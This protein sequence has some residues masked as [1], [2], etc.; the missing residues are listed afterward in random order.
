[1]TL[2]FEVLLHS[3]VSTTVEKTFHFLRENSKQNAFLRYDIASLLNWYRGEARAW[4]EL[5]YTELA[6]FL[7]EPWPGTV[8]LEVAKKADEFRLA[9]HPPDDLAR[10]QTYVHDAFKKESRVD[11]YDSTVVRLDKYDAARHLFEVRPCKYSD[12]LKSN[13]AMDWRGPLE[14]GGQPFSLRSLMARDYPEHLP[15]LSEL[16]LSNAL[17]SA[18][19]VWYRTE[20]GDI[21]PYLPRRA[22]A[23]LLDKA[24]EMVGG[25]PKDQAVFPGAQF[26]CTA[27]GEAEWRP[28]A[29]TFDQMFTADMCK[30]FYEEAGLNRGDLQWIVP[31]ALCREFLRGGKPQL[32]FA[33]FT[34]VAAGGLGDRRRE[35]I[36]R[37]LIAGRQE[38]LDDFLTVK[39]PE[40]VYRDLARYGTI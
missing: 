7:N 36:Q 20:D 19:I 38:V 31:V 15:P 12:G 26:H 1:V 6:C 25:I 14:L 32:F 9:P 29:A 2:F 22:A 11:Q 3:A 23:N 10:L 21:L 16:R 34:N 18:V 24:L 8:S 13:Y 40:Q 33:A 39:S 17:G 5:P 35:A 28:S 37:Q 4:D 27:S 30:E